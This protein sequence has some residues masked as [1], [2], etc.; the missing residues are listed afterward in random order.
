MSCSE[1]IP[2]SI[3]MD[4]R[5]LDIGGVEATRALRET[6]PKIEVVAISSVVSG[7]IPSQILLA[8]ADAFISKTVEA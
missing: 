1:R 4:A 8:G 5:M 2:D 6:F 3:L 7:L